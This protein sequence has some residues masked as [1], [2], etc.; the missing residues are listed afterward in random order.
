MATNQ[1]TTDPF[2]G[3]EWRP[4]VGWEGIYSISS[5]GRV[6]R[7]IIGV[8]PPHSN[9]RPG[10]IR[11][12]RTSKASHYPQVDLYYGERT[13]HSSV[14]TLVARAFLGEP[15]VGSVVNHIDGRKS[16]NALSNLEYVSHAGNCAHAARNG[17]VATGERHGA[18]KVKATDVERMREM[19][20]NGSTAITIGD[21]FGISAST[22]HRICTG[23]SWRCIPANPDNSERVAK[24]SRPR[25]AKLTP[26][27]A[28][29][30]RLACVSGESQRK[31]A[32]RFGV[33]RRT[34]GR[35]LWAHG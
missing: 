16:N 4:V 19:W 6:R 3:E 18:A 17:L 15:S 20:A 31:L 29:E 27:D 35:I 28:I 32:A 1:D 26:A 8:D 9:T 13:E 23:R 33:C 30:I 5:F 24:K 2:A 25:P 22:A 11:S 7:E 10:R 21:S 14:H 12:T 34:I